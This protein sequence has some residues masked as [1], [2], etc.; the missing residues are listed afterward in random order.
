MLFISG[1]EEK[2]I[3]IMNYFHKYWKVLTN[4]KLIAFYNAIKNCF[5]VFFFLIIIIFVYHFLKIMYIC[6][7]YTIYL[8]FP[9]KKKYRLIENIFVKI[10]RKKT[11]IKIRIWFYD[12]LLFF[13]ESSSIVHIFS[14]TFPRNYFIALFVFCSEYEK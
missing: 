5:I 14:K 13:N 10:C 8:T 9:L 1:T 2:E 4:I 6:N 7:S 12:K 3:G 11:W